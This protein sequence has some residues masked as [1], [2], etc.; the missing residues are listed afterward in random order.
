MTAP[1]FPRR[2]RGRHDVRYRRH[3]VTGD[4]NRELGSR[5]PQLA[6]PAAT[7]TFRTLNAADVIAANNS[8]YFG[9]GQDGAVTISGTVTLARDMFLHE[10]Y[11]IGGAGNILKTNGFRVWGVGHARY[12]QRDRRAQSNSIGTTLAPRTTTSSAG[13]TFPAVPYFAARQCLQ[14]PLLERCCGYR[15]R[16]QYHGWIKR[17]QREW[18]SPRSR[19]ASFCGGGG[20]GRSRCQRLRWRGW[21]RGD[22]TDPISYV[23][24]YHRFSFSTS[25]LFRTIRIE[26]RGWW[27]R[28]DELRRRW[29]RWRR[30]WRN[31]LDCCRHDRSR[32]QFDC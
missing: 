27:R 14:W 31:G 6:A 24:I 7:P 32:Y 9:S 22:N 21:N 29:R 11:E 12:Q 17:H 26:R 1:C 5:R 2:L 16:G 18:H 10:S 4:P 19:M 8:F 15:R 13:G 20:S 23:S 30:R 25:H 3:G 28:L